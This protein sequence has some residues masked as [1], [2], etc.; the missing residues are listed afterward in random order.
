MKLIVGL[1]NPGKQYDNT[2]HNVGFMALDHYVYGI[3][4]SFKQ[5]FNG[6]YIQTNISGEKVIFLQPETFMNLSGEAVIKYMN[7]FKID[8]EDVLVVYDDLDMDFGKLRIKGNS[9]AGGH[10]GI[11]SIINHLKTKDF[12]KLKIG[13]RN[14]FK[15]DTKD[16]VLGNFSRQEMKEIDE[17]F[18]ITD[19]VIDDF[20]KG[21]DQLKLMNRYN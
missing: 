2:R 10:N 16:F 5:K 6:K 1:G 17:I 15:K 18:N 3:N 12:L 4:E 11:K 8:V 9:S 7:F 20:I 13:I 14:E 21:D 19:R